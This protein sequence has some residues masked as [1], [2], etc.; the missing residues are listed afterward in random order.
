MAKQSLNTI[1]NW[2][3]TTFKPTQGQFWDAWD[4]FWH[5][6]D[7]IPASSIE[8]LEER[9]NEKADND[10]LQSHLFDDDAHD[11]SQRLSFK[12]N[13]EDLQDEVEARI[14]SDE[15]LQNQIEELR[16]NGG[17]TAVQIRNSL[18]TLSDDDRLDAS[19]IKN[20]PNG[21][22][23]SALPVEIEDTNVIPFNNILS[24]IDEHLMTGDLVIT[25]NIAT[26]KVGC[27]AIQRIISNGTNI[28]DLTAFKKLSTS[29]DYINSPGKVN[30][31][32]FLFDGTNYNV[33]IM[34]NGTSG[35]VPIG[36]AVEQWAA[37][38]LMTGYSISEERKN[39]YSLFVDTLSTQGI[40]PKIKEM[41][42]F[43]GGTANSNV[44]GFKGFSDAVAHGT[45]THASTGTTGDGGDGYFDLGIKPLDFNSGDL[46]LGVYLRK[47]NGNDGH[48]LSCIWGNYTYIT[49]RTSGFL[50]GIAN[51]QN[52]IAQTS[53]KGRYFVTQRNSELS[54]SKD[55]VIKTTSQGPGDLTVGN[56]NFLAFATSP[57]NGS[58]FI[59]S[60]SNQEIGFITIGNALTE[61]ELLIFDEA[62]SLLL[63]SLER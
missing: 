6:D 44:I 43:E 37:R 20:L 13:S 54:A 17:M 25:P 39:A 8:N 55:G 3:K 15:S 59:G 35:V 38:L 40:Y 58:S 27:G 63:T 29:G 60:F 7:K 9:F 36:E 10:A 24:V 61:A 33:G 22:G 47:P 5:K 16:E 32:M 52:S 42:M 18:E 48:Q 49:A 62:L 31:L 34:Q 19:A 41:W 28:P 30:I 53:T 56:H 26:A 46:H 23:G 50:Y 51:I 4:S 1:K 14:N 2:F 57:E 21:G 12:A 11:I 45:L